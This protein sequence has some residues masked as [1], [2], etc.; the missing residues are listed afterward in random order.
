MALT[1]S[2]DGL[3]GPNQVGGVLAY[4]EAQPRTIRHPHLMVTPILLILALLHSLQR[5]MSMLPAHHL[6]WSR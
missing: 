2:E 3:V 5:R 4:G 1:R 6:D